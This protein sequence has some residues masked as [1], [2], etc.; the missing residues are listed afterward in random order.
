MKTRILLVGMLLFAGYG[1]C[2]GG[3]LEDTMGNAVKK[4][5]NRGVNDA[6]DSAYDAAKEGIRG[7]DQKKSSDSPASQK[8]Q[9][10]DKVSGGADSA[11]GPAT[12]EEAEAVYSKYDFIPGDKV[13]FFDDFSDT[14]VG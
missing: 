7:T 14:D 5:G 2:H 8:S 1:L 4:L 3:W 13:I 6:G 10:K 11:A 12:I 9:R